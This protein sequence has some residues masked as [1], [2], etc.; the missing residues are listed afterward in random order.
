MKSKS[1]TSDLIL[2]QKEG[3]FSIKYMDDIFPI[4]EN[5]RRNFASEIAWLTTIR[6]LLV[7]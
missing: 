2:G 3:H 7:Y 6:L 1:V 4:F 5:Q